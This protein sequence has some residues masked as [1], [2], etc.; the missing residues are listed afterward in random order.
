MTVMDS[1]KADNVL[2]EAY[3]FPDSEIE[4]LGGYLG[5]NYLVV[6]KER[7]FVLKAF[8]ASHDSRAHLDAQIAAI[9]TA[10]QNVSDI[11]FP[12]I[13]K[14]V[15]DC[16]MHQTED[17]LWILQKFVEGD[18]VGQ[19]APAK[20][21][22]LHSVG[23]HV[24]ALDKALEG[25]YHAGAVRRDM[26]WDLV[27]APLYR[28][29]VELVEDPEVRRLADY[30][31]LQ[32]E[33]D[34]AGQLARLPRQIVHND[35]HRFA[36]MTND[37]RDR[38]QGIIDFGDLTLTHRICHLAI[39]LSD[40]LTGQNDFI[41]AAQT[42]VEAYHG[43]NPLTEIEV[44]QLYFL[45]GLRLGLYV[46][47]AAWM[48]QNQADNCHA[49]SKLRD[50]EQNL[51]S[52]VAVNPMA[53]EDAM[54]A[55]CHMHVPERDKEAARLAE[56]REAYFSSSLY[57]HYEEPLVLERGALQYLYGLDGKTYLDCVNNVSQSGHCH[58]HIARATRKQ[59]SHLNTNSRYVYAQMDELAER[60]LAT[61]PAELDTVFFLNSGSEAN[62]L[63]MRLAKSFTGSDEFIVLDEAYHG[64]STASTDISPNRI[65]R[66]GGMGLPDYVHR[67]MLPDAYRNLPIDHKG[68]VVDAFLHE[69]PELI[70]RTKGNLAAFIAESLIGTGGQIAFPQN[71][72]STI[73]QAVRAAGGLAIADEVQVG[74]GRTGDMWCF[75]E[76]GVVP[77]IV[78]MGKP[79]ANG[80]P[81]GAIV[82]KRAIAEAFDE[83]VV[84]FNTFGGNP[85]S[86]AT[87]IAVLEVLQRDK[88]QENV[89]QQT[90]TLRQG[91][92]ALQDKHGLIGDVRGRGLY[93]GVELVEDRDSKEPAKKRAKRCIEAMK[94]RGFLLN[95]NGYFNNI[96]KIKPPL[97][98]ND[99]NIQSLL[100]N[101]D[102][103]LSEVSK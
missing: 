87:A 93:V 84:Y 36:L 70:D 38:V 44:Q 91:L 57:T 18:L 4:D 56:H 11:A 26:Q 98:V 59:V 5:R 52:L 9:E 22:L 28:D 33:T 21:K 20:G 17:G 81:M 90:D 15:T 82:T 100:T 102:A 48:R 46:A 83:K 7:K 96:I 63:A 6:S 69:L 65:G 35:C 79:I 99:A 32:F 74:F 10:S 54:R 13:I 23:V 37:A 64:N 71:Y 8:A 14:T 30:F 67:L 72:L 45:I 60:L 85:V 47:H 75:E 19:G 68:P 1:K 94:Q 34:G 88:L 43:V 89:R 41:T 103:V 51:R 29:R 76:Q 31:F 53:F 73:Y 61:F 66:P 92:A 50:V 95:T 86:C 77:D 24:A 97:I 62:D 58:P 27:D 49:Q 40:F 12:D 78:T 101:L 80:H 2:A 16:D 25:F 3:G 42:V 55:A 39:T